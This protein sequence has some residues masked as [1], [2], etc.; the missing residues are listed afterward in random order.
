MAHERFD[1]ATIKYLV[2]ENYLGATASKNP[3]PELNLGFKIA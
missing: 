3:W 2:D 1:F